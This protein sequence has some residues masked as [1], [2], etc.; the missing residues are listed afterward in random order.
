LAKEKREAD[1]KQSTVAVLREGIMP[2]FSGT[3]QSVR[4]WNEV[5]L[6]T[7]LKDFIGQL[8]RRR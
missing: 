1:R 3:R 2:V 7:L 5:D 4:T 8:L 6:G